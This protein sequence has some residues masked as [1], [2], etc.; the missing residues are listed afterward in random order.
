[1]T[2]FEANDIAN[3][4]YVSRQLSRIIEGHQS[5]TWQVPGGGAAASVNFDVQSVD[6]LARVKSR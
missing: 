1:M 2:A 6:I 4:D 3:A 5:S